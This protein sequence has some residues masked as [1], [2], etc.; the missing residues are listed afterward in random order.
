MV[1][2][3]FDLHVC[4]YSPVGGPEVPVSFGRVPVVLGH[5]RVLVLLAE[6]APAGTDMVPAAPVASVLAV[7]HSVAM[8]AVV[9]SWYQVR[10]QSAATEESKP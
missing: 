8:Q 2:A 4:G 7:E 5:K 3:R 6:P 9:A 1:L 10:E